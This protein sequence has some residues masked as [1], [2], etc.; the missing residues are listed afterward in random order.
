[1]VA[2]P[3]APMLVEFAGCS[4]PTRSDYFFP[5]S[6]QARELAKTLTSDG[7]KPIWVLVDTR[8]LVSTA[9]IQLRGDSSQLSQA[10][11]SRYRQKVMIGEWLLMRVD[12]SDE[13]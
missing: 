1:M 4:N 8:T 3:Y 5:A 2:V 6:R 13:H 12:V 10:L 11:R 7:V 9:P